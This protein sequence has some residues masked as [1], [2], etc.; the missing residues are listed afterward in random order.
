MYIFKEANAEDSHKIWKQS[1]N[2]SI[3]TNPE[4]L[5]SLKNISYYSVYNGEEPICCWPVHTNENGNLVIP[6]FF[7]YFGPFWSNAILKL[8]NHSWLAKST[9]VYECFLENLTQKHN[10][11][12]FQFHHTLSDVRIFDWWNYNTTKNKFDINVKYTAL[13]NQLKIKN[14]KEILSHFRYVRRYEIKNFKE[15]ESKVYLC[16]G[17]SVDELITMYFKTVTE[18]HSKEYEQSL[19]EK[20]IFFHNMC[21]KNFGKIFAYREKK[22]KKLICLILILID[23]NSA[24]LILNL[25]TKEW[26]NENI[27]SWAI[28]K[29]FLYIKTINIDVLDFN[30]ANSP[31]LGDDKQSYGSIAKPY[32]N[33]NF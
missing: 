28:H 8:P 31:K 18:K 20:L 30:G 23:Q 15:N 27:M 24:H 1:P 7:Y 26:K 12:N 16:N 17:V 33:F 25:S 22:S 19:I 32:F 13:I 14:E 11:I 5:K 9:K 2:A 10:K 3:F 21:N 6:D 29:L 4:F